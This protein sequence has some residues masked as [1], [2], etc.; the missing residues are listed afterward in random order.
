MNLNKFYVFKQQTK[1]INLAC[2]HLPA[3]LAFWEAQQHCH[4]FQAS[5]NYSE[6]L[7]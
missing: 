3:I 4:E 7:C 2:W 1:L 5:L 6:T